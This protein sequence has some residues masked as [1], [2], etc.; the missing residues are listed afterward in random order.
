LGIWNSK[1]EVFVLDILLPQQNDSLFIDQFSCTP[2]DLMLTM[3][4][5]ASEAYCPIC[6]V[7]S[8][9]IHSRYQRTLFDLPLACHC[10]LI[11]LQ[12]RRFFCRVT[13]CPRR[14]FTERLPALAA[15]YAHRTV[16]MVTILRQIGLALGGQA[17]ARLATNLRLIASHDTILRFLRQTPDEQP[18]SSPPV[19]GI[20]DFCF[21]KGRTY[22]TI[23]VD[24][25][26]GR[27][28][29]L[30]PDREAGTVAAWLQ[31]HPGARIISRDRA[32]AYAEGAKLGAPSAQQV[33]D[34]FHVLKNLGDALEDLLMRL[35][36]QLRSLMQQPAEPA[37]PAEAD[38]AAANGVE[39]GE[40]GAVT[41]H[42]MVGVLPAVVDPA[43]REME[44]TKAD[45]ANDTEPQMRPRRRDIIQRE[46]R[47]RTWLAR[48]EEVQYLYSHGWSLVAIAEKLDLHRE[49]VAKWVRNT[50]NGSSPAS[51]PERQ[52][53][54]RR[55]SK[56]DQHK[57]YLRHR[58]T[59]GNSNARRLWEEL[60]GQRGYRGGYSMVAD[61]VTRLR[62]EHGIPLRKGAYEDRCRPKRVPLARAR[63]LRWLLWRAANELSDEEYQ[64]VMALCHHSQEVTLAYGLVT[65]FRSLVQRREGCQ[66]AN[67]VELAEGSGVAEIA[68][69]A[70]GVLRDFAAVSAGM[71]L[72]WSQGR[73]EG[74]VNRLKMLKRQ[75]Y[76]RA[77]FDLLRLRVLHAG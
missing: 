27:V 16:R 50:S 41:E 58:W 72:E 65:D 30:L 73:V 66:L 42:L 14:I 17:G 59:Q 21:R 18:P 48:Y 55:S 15:P 74:N 71:T 6:Q 43:K 53:R 9:R 34:R 70:R 69:F 77:K 64:T 39:I 49:T 25:E 44:E 10:V 28:V 29:D 62:Q 47:R 31:Q 46:A 13:D 68:S 40:C 76:G 75:T 20:D 38:G 61:Y 57:V 11:R 8:T 63:E 23:L 3:S 52:P 36:P 56:L 1:E 60:R 4:A 32:S 5:T 51:S 2:T 67:W 54:P 7:P 45:G 37:E 12:V 26:T 35:H 19:L 22:G 24:L 33:A